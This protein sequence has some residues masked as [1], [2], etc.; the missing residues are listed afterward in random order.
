VLD[1][2]P[3]DVPLPAGSF[4][5]VFLLPAADGTLVLA[6]SSRDAAGTRLHVVRLY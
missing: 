6:W 3:D 1:L 4:D 5:D 2:A